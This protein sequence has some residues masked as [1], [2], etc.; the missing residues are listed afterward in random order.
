MDEELSLRKFVPEEEARKTFAKV[1]DKSTIRALHRLSTKHYFDVLEFVVSTGKEAHVFRAR[2]SSGNYRAVKVYKTGTSE[3]NSMARY[4]E[5]DMRFSRV[6]SGKRGI[7]FAWTKKEFSNLTLIANAGVNCPMPLAFFENALVMEFIGSNGEAS[8]TLKERPPKDIGKAYDF[9]VDALARLL[10]GA[11][12]VHADLSEYNILNREEELFIID[13]GQAVLTSHPE[14]ES[15]F[16]R[17]LKNM[18]KFFSRLGLKKSEAEMMQDVRA[19][20]PK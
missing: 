3:F 10:F 6:K 5:G 13:V 16:Q 12:L 9:V 7:V 11:G 20:K 1:F 19:R 17:D 14:A 8:P 2:D 15:F 4:I 18:A